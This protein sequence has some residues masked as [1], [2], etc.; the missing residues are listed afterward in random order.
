VTKARFT[1]FYFGHLANGISNQGTQ[2]VKAGT[3]VACQAGLYFGGLYA[4]IVFPGGFSPPS[5]TDF[6]RSPTFLLPCEA[7]D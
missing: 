2:V 1:L 6:V 3:A 7:K 4:Q 5:V